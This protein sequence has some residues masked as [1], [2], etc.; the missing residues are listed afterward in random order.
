MA[1]LTLPPVTL[2]LML[3]DTTQGMVPWKTVTLPVTGI[4][5]PEMS[6]LP[7][8]PI[9]T[10][11]TETLPI[12]AALVRTNTLPVA[13]S[14]SSAC[15]MLRRYQGWTLAGWGYAIFSLYLVYLV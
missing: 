8:A 15:V 14:S 12:K 11:P 4:S 9:A 2:A 6:M 5:L 13:S 1:T 10:L 3:P 7:S